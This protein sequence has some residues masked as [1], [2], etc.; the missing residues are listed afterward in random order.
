M[1]SSDI[2]EAEGIITPDMVQIAAREIEMAGSEVRKAEVR[3]PLLDNFCG[4]FLCDLMLLAQE[5]IKQEGNK[6]RF[7]R[8]DN[9]VIDLAG[10]SKRRF[11]KEDKVVVDLTS[12]E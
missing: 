2:L 3:D 9:V 6:K 4:A 11:T 8:E 12:E 1:R 5:T 7:T 10:P